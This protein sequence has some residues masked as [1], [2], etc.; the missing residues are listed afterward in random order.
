M[1]KADR[2]LMAARR[3]LDA[4]DTETAADRAYYAVFYAAWAL[5]DAEGS[6]RP[7]THQGLITEFSRLYVKT[8][9]LDPTI[10]AIV[11]R[12][13]NLRLIADYTLQ[14]IPAPDARRALNEAE[15]FISA[16]RAQLTP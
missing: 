13:Q 3:A 2:A 12:L 1:D 9:R 5:L 6:P 11:A 8:R 16:A 15:D 4:K 7:R 14:P 10:G